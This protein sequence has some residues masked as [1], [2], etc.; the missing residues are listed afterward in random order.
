MRS[1]GFWTVFDVGGQGIIYLFDN[2][3]FHPPV[4]TG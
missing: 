4:K 1:D 2:R 3:E